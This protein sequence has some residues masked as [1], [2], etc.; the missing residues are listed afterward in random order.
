MAVRFVTRNAA[1]R[2][3][4]ALVLLTILG[5]AAGHYMCR[6]GGKAT[7]TAPATK[8]SAVELRKHVQTLAGEIGE[9]NVFCEKQL[10]QAADY[11]EQAW[12]SQGYEVKRYPDTGMGGECANLEV[13]R[14]GKTRPTEII[15][16]GAHYDSVAGSPGANDNASGVAALLEISNRFATNETDRTVRFVAFV[17]EEP[18]FYET[19][20]MGSRVYAKMAR[21]RG[22]D[23]RAMISL[24]TI[25][26]YTDAANSQHFPSPLFGFFYPDRGNFLGFVSDLSSRP[27]LRSAVAA[28]RAHSDFPTECIATF[29]GVAGVGWSDHA[30]FWREGY[31]AIMASDTA[32]FRYPYYHTEQDTPDKINYDALARVTDGLL[33][34]TVSLAND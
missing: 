3:G 27:L 10:R 12:R 23:I 7:H 1:F 26:Y 9:H 28:F 15:L 34:M 4:F 32:P 22:D 14:R 11:I 17:N 33:E 21:Q 19:D 25:G 20:Q 13:T 18:P 31:P 16:L 24:E 30:S 2:I 6:C 29:R 8:V 5:C